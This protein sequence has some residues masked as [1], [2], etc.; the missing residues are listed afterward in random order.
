MTTTLRVLLEGETVSLHP[1]PTMLS[2]R[3]HLVLVVK[4]TL[5]STPI[6]TLQDT[7]STFMNRVGPVGIWLT[8]FVG[9][10]PRLTNIAWTGANQPKSSAF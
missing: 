10:L 6:R 1:F 4:R 8:G 2:A 5:A 7:N 3:A 9:C